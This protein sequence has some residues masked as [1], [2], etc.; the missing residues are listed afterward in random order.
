MNFKKLSL[1]LFICASLV[2][3]S[4]CGNNDNTSELQTE[5]EQVE[6]WNV[7]NEGMEEAEAASSEV[8]VSEN[9]EATTEESDEDTAE[10]VTT[11]TES[12]ETS[13]G[14][15]GGNTSG[16]GTLS[17]T[18]N[19]NGDTAEKEQYEDEQAPSE[20]YTPDVE[21]FG[22][23]NVADSIPLSTVKV[24]GNVL[25]IR[26]ETV[27]SFINT[28][29]LRQNKGYSLSNY[30]E[31]DNTYDGIFWYGKG[32]GIYNNTQ[33]EVKRF[34]GT[35]IFIEGIESGFVAA[36]VDPTVESGY[37][38]RSVYAST[39]TTENDFAIEFVSGVKAG[40]TRSEIEALFQSAGDTTKTYTYYANKDAALLIF[41]DENDTAMEIYLFADYDF[42]PI[43]Y[44]EKE[45]PVVEEMTEESTKATVKVISPESAM[46]VG[47]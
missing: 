41:Y 38:I 30:F 44:S 18:P 46:Q 27:D 35:H 40:M 14:G 45:E 7:S 42:M 5:S 16:N 23:K 24:N 13:N 31:T 36:I 8:N 25:D 47:R 33:D 11:E 29:G 4:A 3:F 43:L 20:V 9:S 37:Q 21:I 2:S 28:A 39:D 17:G 32:Y 15:T 12:G 19:G 34:T 26:E 1:M 10:D 6:W 22:E